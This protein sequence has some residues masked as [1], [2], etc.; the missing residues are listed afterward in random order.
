MPARNLK[1]QTPNQ[2]LNDLNQYSPVIVTYDV[3]SDHSTAKPAFVAPFPMRIVD[4][5]VAAQATSGSGSITPRKGTDAM[6]TAIGCA[7][8]GAV[9]RFA[10]GAV[11]ANKAFMVLA[12]GDT[13]NVIANG[14]TDRGIVTFIG[15][16]V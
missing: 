2:Q 1:G 7:T 13:V 5:I 10:A 15:V 4:I 11:V 6:C 14:S 9:A 8:D 12:K 16:R 3:A